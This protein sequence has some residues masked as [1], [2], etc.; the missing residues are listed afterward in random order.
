MA[1]PEKHH[2]WTWELTASPEAL[3]PLVSD[4]ERFNRDCGYPA[5]QVVPPGEIVGP[6]NPGTRRLRTRHLGLLIEWDERPFEWVTGRRFGVERIFQRGPFSVI[7]ALCELTPRQ[8]S[9]TTLVYQVWFTTANALGRLA[10]RFGAAAWQFR[11]PFDRVFKRYD[12]LAQ[13]GATQAVLTA[14]AR[15]SPGGSTRLASLK[16]ALIGQGKQPVDLVGRLAGYIATTDDLSAQR[17]RAYALADQWKTDRRATLKLCLHATRVGLLDFQWDVLCPHCRGAKAVSSSLYGLNPES[18]CDTC[19]IDFVASFDQSIELT[20]TPNAAVRRVRRAEYCIGGPQ[21]TPHIVVQETIPPGA[22]AS[23]QFPLEPGRFRARTATDP[24][25]RFFRIEPG[26]AVALKMVLG[27]A[28]EPAEE[29]ALAPGADLTLVNNTTGA[30]LVILEHLAWS[31]QATT[32]A[33]VTSLQ[34]FRDLFSR[35]VLRPGGQVSVSSLTV[36]FTDLKGS[37]Q[38]YLEIGDAPA[39]GRV[40][41]HFD[42]LKVAVEAEGGAIV[43]TM[44]DAI[45]AVFPRPAPALRA[46]HV[47]QRQLALARSAIPWNGPP[48][49]APLP[50]PLILKTGLHH[51][52]C[53]AINQND[54]LDYFGTTVNIAARLCSLSTGRDL[55]LSESVRS[56][57][58]V[59]SYLSAQ[60]ASL[61]TSAERARLR[62]MGDETFPVWRVKRL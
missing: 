59:A 31:D 40:L 44:G 20:F 26:A 10:L 9:G 8:P 54:R 57:A 33:E 55:V 13:S 41:T 18:Y 11:I 42:I 6:L 34:L 5:V 2:R 15:L 62:G 19:Q 48:G 53:I 27:S 1:A 50:S 61:Q 46:M 4:T 21:V 7:R 38:L 28:P 39:F 49:S 58:E 36:L 47:A 43:K 37:T 45:M 30:Q 29:M 25:P 3:W 32:A 51:G 56:D 52:P 17:I 35:E 16:S 24:R 23:I 60:E 22:A 12:R 14:R